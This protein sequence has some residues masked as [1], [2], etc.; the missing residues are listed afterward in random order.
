MSRIFK[1]GFRIGILGGG[2]LA[3]M[4]ALSA[5][6]LGAIPY[7]LSASEDDPAQQVVERGFLGDVSDLRALK[8]FSEHVD[9]ITFESEFIDCD[10]LE[11]AVPTH[12]KRIFPSL[13]AIRTLQDR[14]TQKELLNQYKIATSDWSLVQD[15]LSALDAV[16]TFEFPVVMKKRRN[17]YDGNGTFIIKNKKE[18]LMFV[19][20]QLANDDA[21]IAEKFVPFDRELACLFS[22]DQYN[23]VLQ[24]PLVES[25]QKDAKCFWVK[26]PIQHKKFSQWSKKFKLLLKKINYIGTI[27]V[28]LF[29][30]DGELYVN[31]LAPRVHN[32]G[33]YSMDALPLSQ[34]DAHIRALANLELPL[35]LPATSCFAMVNLLGSKNTSTP[36]WELP[37]NTYLHWYG[38]KENRAGRKM[39]HIN[40]L[41]TN[42]EKALKLAL[43]NLKGFNL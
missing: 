22:R 38:K 33:H 2:Q 35:E 14:K 11:A 31:E 28:E 17:G 37:P 12:Q 3:R 1:P 6:N 34:F 16:E 29:D 15:E 36:V 26:G 18:L 24:F 8:A 25:L 30:K 19:K 4:L 7:I 20:K 5:H 10:I 39:G 42:P 41:S 32:S 21:F 43:Q 13:A 23:H 27:G 40:T 9:V